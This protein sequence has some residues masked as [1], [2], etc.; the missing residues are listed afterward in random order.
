MEKV[1]AHVIKL[2]I[3]DYLSGP[4]SNLSVLITKKRTRQRHLGK[5]YVKRLKFI[6]T[7]PGMSGTTRSWLSPGVLQNRERIIFCPFQPA[8]VGYVL[9][10][11]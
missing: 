6:A 5:G 10:Q 4:E 3:L 8:R 1:F 7:S 2:R 11:P 9:Q